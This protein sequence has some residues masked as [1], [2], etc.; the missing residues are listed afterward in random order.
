METK[1]CNSCGHTKPV[2]DF[3]TYKATGK[4]RGTCKACAK[5]AAKRH[6]WAKTKESDLL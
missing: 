1:T 4:P 5:A 6:Y 2:D 3:Y